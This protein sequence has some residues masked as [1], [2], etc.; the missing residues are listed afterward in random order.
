MSDKPRHNEEPHSAQGARLFHFEPEKR[1]YSA[2]GEL[3]DAAWFRAKGQARAHHLVTR[4]KVMRAVRDYFEGQNFLEVETP[5]AVPS[6]GLDL[7]L[8]AAAVDLGKDPRWL[9]TS[10]EYQMKRL[11]S[12]GFER[13]FQICKCFRRGEEGPNHE[14]EF[15]MLEWYRANA[16]VGSVMRD[17]EALTAFAATRVRGTTQLDVRGHLVDLAT[18]WDRMSVHEAFRHFANVE[19]DDVLPDEERFYRILVEEIE[20]NLGLKKPVLLHSYPASMASLA[21]LDP[22]NPKVAERFEAYVAGIELCNGFGELIDANEQRARLLRDQDMRRLLGKDVYPL[23]EKFLDA[24]DVGMPES[25]GNALGL[26]RLVMII[27]GANALQD[28]VAFS[29]RRL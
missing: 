13:I 11:L 24:L 4:A 8:D 22:H 7:H 25:G 16:D 21:R 23:D 20:P 19:V 14:P 6:P 28:I 2:D 15:T 26:D 18:P 5:L 10:P 29:A 27:A 1:A 9:I 12:A 3:T 17:T